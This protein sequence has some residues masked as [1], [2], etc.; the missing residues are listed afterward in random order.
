MFSP[1]ERVRSHLCKSD[2]HD[3]DDAGS[4]ALVCSAHPTSLVF[5]SHIVQDEL[6][7]QFV[8]D[9]PSLLQRVKRRRLSPFDSV[10]EM[11]VLS[12]TISLPEQQQQH[13]QQQQSRITQPLPIR[14]SVFSKHLSVP[15][16]N[17][18]P[19]AD[20]NK[21]VEAPAADIIDD[22]FAM[23]E[24]TV[25]LP[26]DPTP[27]CL[28]ELTPLSKIRYLFL[29]LTC[30]HAYV[31]NPYGRLVGII[32]LRDLIDLK[33]SQLEHDETN[34][35]TGN[36]FVSST[37]YDYGA[38]ESITSVA[39]CEFHCKFILNPQTNKKNVLKRKIERHAFSR[40]KNNRQSVHGSGEREKK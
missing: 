39:L 20:A 10:V 27:L 23:E 7:V 37:G 35:H 15:N 30:N 9:R 38:L 13:Q 12:S 29:Q 1:D 17:S 6:R 24:A 40:N 8:I 36:S 25:Y 2:A 31:K 14:P 26:A 4:F 16:G 21:D 28:D 19:K 34:P 3:E 18:D 33:L 11:T 5:F 32:T 22:L